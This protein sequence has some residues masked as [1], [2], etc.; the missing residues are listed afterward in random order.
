LAERSEAEN[1]VDRAPAR[2]R[3][4]K[5]RAAL[6]PVTVLAWCLRHLASRVS[7][8]SRALGTFAVALRPRDGFSLRGFAASQE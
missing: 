8:A 3:M 4:R 2:L 7:H 1:P 6:P 5:Q